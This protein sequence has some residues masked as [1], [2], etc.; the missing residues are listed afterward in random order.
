MV[1]E[2]SP[3]VRRCVV[4]LSI[5][6]AAPMAMPVLAL[7]ITS[8]VAYSYERNDNSS[9]TATQEENGTVHTP[10]LQLGVSH[11]DTTLDVGI[12]YTASR[13][14]FDEEEFDDNTIIDGTGYLTWNVL[15]ERLI[16]DLRNERSE[17]TIDAELQNTPDNRQTVSETTAN[18]E[19]NQ[20]LFAGHILTIEAG[21]QEYT[22][23]ETDNDSSGENYSVSY[24]VPLG[25]QSNVGVIYTNDDT[26][27]DAE[28]GIDYSSESVQL[29]FNNTTGA[30]SLQAAVGNT[31][32]EQEGAPGFD[33]VTG[34]LNFGYTISD[35]SNVTLDI[36]RTVDDNSLGSGLIP[37][38]TIN[39]QLVDNS[40]LNEV[41]TDTRASVGYTAAVGRYNIALQAYQSEVKFENVPQNEERQGA[42]IQITRQFSSRLSAAISLAQN[43]YE[44]TDTDRT[45][46]VYDAEFR[47]D[48]QANPRLN[49]NLVYGYFDRDSSADDTNDAEVRTVLFT[50][51]YILL[52][53]N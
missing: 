36:G 34:N 40:G 11:E 10:S 7:E 53:A 28:D 19:Y 29:F 25:L 13:E 3:F 43:E 48:Y 14:Y 15:P 9:L 24:T 33:A 35:T 49:M 44:F 16:F 21:A 38:G 18:I 4:G 51:S 42:N 22:T 32:V 8:Q 46:T 45:D 31:D 5:S 30:F 47:V 23:N 37:T 27:F 12:D 6:L 2:R 52:G 1:W 26:N 50:V 17:R 39:E 20:P 41:F